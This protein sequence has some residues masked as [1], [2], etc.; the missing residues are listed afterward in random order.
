MAFDEVAATYDATFGLSPSGRLFRFRVAERLMSALRPRSQVLDI[1]CGTGEDALWLARQGHVVRGIDASPAMIAAATAKVLGTKSAATFE[2]RSLESLKAEG[3]RFD[4]V[5]S[6]FGVLNCV[7]LDTWTEIVPGL[8]ARDGRGCVVVMGDRPLPEAL[9]FGAPKRPRGLGA[10]VRVGTSTVPTFYEPV[11][12]VVASLSTR[13]RVTHVEAL[14]CLVP[15]PTYADFPRRHPLA[16]G[17]LA[18]GE[19]V[20]RGA[21][22]FRSRGDH[23]LFEFT[24]L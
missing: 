6:D 5:L 16:T 9:R 23:T 4:A 10:P 18:M 14:G 22:F 17:L 21:P 2:C 12:A 13:A 15:G 3:R 19:S 7:P 1:G 24:P 20:F 8:L 11:S